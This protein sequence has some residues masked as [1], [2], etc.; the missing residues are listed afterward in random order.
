[1]T[2]TT[3]EQ[4]GAAV[5]PIVEGL[6]YDLEDLAVR[7]SGGRREV[8][9]IVDR[10]GG[11]SLD[12][13][14]DVSRQLSDALDEAEAFGDDPYELEIS[15]P[16]VD[17]PLTQPR[18]WRRARGR[19]VT[20][21][22]VVDGATE[23]VVGRVGESTEESVTLVHN[24]KGRFTESTL[25]YPSIERAVVEVDFTRPGPAELRRCGLDD[26]EIARRRE[27]AQ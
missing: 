5:R 26:D 1:M 14:A 21:R 7:D 13:V 3:A 24:E 16:G 8:T 6:G 23:T 17:R 27:P 18:H 12:D 4:I 19:K 9:I 25:D 11:A 20:V 15:T 10:D 22:Q 2:A